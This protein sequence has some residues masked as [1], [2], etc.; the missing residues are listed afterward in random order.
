MRISDVAKALG[1][2]GGLARARRLSAAD[3]QRIAALGGHARRRSLEMRRRIID[4][5]A[6]AK[7]ADELRR[8]AAPRIVRV[9]TCRGPLPGLY[10]RRD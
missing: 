7:A 2:L 6:Y 8:P 1:A 4:T 3:R 9:S 10:A 5:M